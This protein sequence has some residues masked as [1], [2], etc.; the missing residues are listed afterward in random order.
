M[1]GEF[2]ADPNVEDVNENLHTQVFDRE[3]LLDVGDS[4]VFL[5]PGDLV[6]LR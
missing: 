3:E 4:R 1:D 5:R 2:K 6:E